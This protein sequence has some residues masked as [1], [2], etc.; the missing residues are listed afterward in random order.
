MITQIEKT[1]YADNTCYLRNQLE[2]NHLQLANL[3]NQTT[4]KG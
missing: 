3:R 4:R 1:D 2:E